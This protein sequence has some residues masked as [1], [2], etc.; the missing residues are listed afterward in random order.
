MDGPRHAQP[1]GPSGGAED[2]LGSGRGDGRDY[3]GFSRYTASLSLSIWY[4]WKVQAVH[5]DADHAKTLSPFS[6]VL[7][8]VAT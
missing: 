2:G 3:A 6:R 1:H 8:R 5:A 7:S 4:T